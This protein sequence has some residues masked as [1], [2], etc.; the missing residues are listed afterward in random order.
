MFLLVNWHAS[1]QKGFY[2]QAYISPRIYPMKPIWA[3]T[4]TIPVL[5][6]SL[7]FS[8]FTLTSHHLLKGGGNPKPFIL[9]WVPSSALRQVLITAVPLILSWTLQMQLLCLEQYLFFL[10]Q[11]QVYIWEAFFFFQNRSFQNCTF[12]TGCTTT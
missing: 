5:L 1:L 10:K 3:C 12:E 6:G 2:L 9:S 7:C 4:S 8:S 11:C